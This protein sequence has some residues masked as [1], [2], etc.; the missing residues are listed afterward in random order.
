[1]APMSIE[2]FWLLPRR[3]PGANLNFG[4]KLISFVPQT[5]IPN[6]NLH[7]YARFIEKI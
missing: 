1:M 2:L 5:V 3:E 4:R 6:F 7:N